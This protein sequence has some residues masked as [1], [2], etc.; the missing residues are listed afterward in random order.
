MCLIWSFNPCTH[1]PT[2]AQPFTKTS[3]QT[4]ILT[5]ILNLYLSDLAT[6]H[7]TAHPTIHATMYVTPHPTIQTFNHAYTGNHPLTYLPP[8]PASDIL[9]NKKERKR[10]SI[11]RNFVGDY[12]GFVDNPSLRALV[13]TVHLYSHTKHYHTHV[14]ILLNTHEIYG[15]IEKS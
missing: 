2:A 3:T 6:I 9:L 5:L 12:L 8:T 10:L 1:S 11:N 4:S 15:E 13:G 7:P 14:Y